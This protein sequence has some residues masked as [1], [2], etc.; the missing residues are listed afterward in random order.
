MKSALL[1]AIGEDG[2][3]KLFE[4]LHGVIE[5]AGPAPVDDD[6]PEN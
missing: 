4:L 6:E 3:D 2:R 1:A 5:A